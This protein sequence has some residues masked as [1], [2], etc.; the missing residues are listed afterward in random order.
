MNRFAQRLRG[1]DPGLWVAL[2]LPIFAI[3]PLVRHPGLPNTADG[4][5]HLMRQVELDQAWQ[6]GIFY[7]RWAADLALGHG[8]PLFNYAPPVLYQMTQVLRVLGLP[9]DEAMKGTIILNFELYSLGMFLFARRVFGSPAALLAAAGYVYAPYRLRE[10]FIQGNYGQFT[11]LA[12]YPLILWA[13]HG[14]ITDRRPRRFILPASLAWSGL[15]LSHNISTMLFGPLFIAYLVFLLVRRGSRQQ[16]V[17]PR[18]WRRLGLTLFATGL[19]LGL[20]ALFWLPAFG[21]RDQIRLEGITAGFFDFRQSFISLAELVA[22]PRPLDLAAMNPEF[23]LALG[24]GQLA[25]AVLAILFLVVGTGLVPLAGRATAPR[26]LP[27]TVARFLKQPV[28]AHL[29]FF[30]LALTAYAFLALPGSRT[31]WETIPLLELA[32]F[33]WRMLGPAVMAAAFLSGGTF[34]LLSKQ[35]RNLNPRLP[36]KTISRLNAIVLLIGILSFV[37][38]NL[39]YLVPAQF[40][41]W[42]T[43]SIEDAFAYEVQS[44]AIGTTSTGEFLPRWAE[45]FPAPEALQP[46]YEAGRRPQ[47]VDPAS[48]PPAASAK[49]LAHRAQSDRIEIETPEA[50]GATIRTLYW[51]G[52]EARLDGRPLPIAVTALT[53][54]IRV[55]IPPGQHQLELR[56]ADT[57]LRNIANIISMLSL[58][59]WLAS[60]VI[61]VRLERRQTSPLLPAPELSSRHWTSRLDGE[62]PISSRQAWVLIGALVIGAGLLQLTGNSFR[63]RSDPN[64]P[65]PAERITAVDFADQIRLVGFDSGPEVIRPGDSLLVVAYWR[66]LR[67]LETDYAF[68]LHLDDPSGRT[69]LTFDERHPDNIPTS[70]WPPGL[71]HRQPLQLQIPE[72]LAPIRYT[73]TAGLYNPA[74]GGRLP[75]ASGAGDGFSLGQ[76]WFEPKQAQQAGQ[77]PALPD[78]IRF[79]SS[80]ELVGLV[81]PTDDLHPEGDINLDLYWKANQGVSQDYVIFVHL[82]DAAGRIMTQS[83]GVPYHGLYP[84]RAWRPDQIIIDARRLAAPAQGNRTPVSIAIGVYDPVTGDRLPAVTTEG[85]PLPDNA[86]IVR[87]P[88]TN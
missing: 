56:L 35:L 85:E 19:G 37:I 13:F 38:F 45:R 60:L 74:N 52:W 31:L 42:G 80:I 75:L 5:A 48:L 46:D 83:D 72:D 41:R 36:I 86:F 55:D 58:V 8:L 63:L 68:F 49:M 6:Q 29:I 71:Y 14:L 9:L 39:Y 88:G 10:A 76:V 11:G 84:T 81:L 51:P 18:R 44:G 62:R 4:P 32:E 53:G 17:R 78:P 28:Q 22:A 87:F 34:Y 2:L 7:P 73:L 27:G 65:L 70:R 33:P 50:F 30:G 79:G 12:F 64:H 77:S 66:A 40:I 20:S 3:L 26:H 69:W 59:I 67:P 23:P 57:P 21:E 15:L 16:E 54:L 82:L 61:V 1:A 25:G 47:K 24:L 43:P